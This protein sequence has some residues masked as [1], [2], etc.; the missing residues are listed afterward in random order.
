MDNVVPLAIRSLGTATEEPPA[1]RWL[2]SRSPTELRDLQLAD[3][4]LLPIIR[5]L[6]EGVEPPQGQLFVR[7]AA[8][9]HL[10]RCC[11]QL[12]LCQ[13]VLYY[14]W[15]LSDRVHIKLVAPLGLRDEILYLAH[16][17]RS[18]SHQGQDRTLSRVRASFFW[19]SL[20]LDVALYIRT[21]AAC[22]KNKKPKDKARA[23][24]TSFHAGVP[25]ERVHLDILGPLV[26][27][28]AGNRYVLMMVDQFTKWVECIPLP[29]QTAERL[30]EAALH[31]FFCR[32]GLPLQIHTD[33][34]RN[35]TGHV[36]SDL[37]A[38]LQVAK[39]RTTP[40]HPNANGQVERYN[41]TL[42]QAIRCLLPERQSSWD[43][44]LL[45][46]GMAL[47]AG[48]NRT[49]GFSPNLMM[50][51]REVLSPLELATG[52]GAEN[53][54]EQEPAQ[55]VRELLQR[56]KSVHDEARRHV[57]LVQRAQKRMYDLHL[58]ERSYEKGDLVYQR[59]EAGQVGQSKKLQPIFIGPVLVTQVLS[60]V[61]YRVENRK[62][63]YVLRH[64]RLI[65]CKDRVIPLWVRRKRHDL[66]GGDTTLDEDDEERRQIFFRSGGDNR[67]P[68]PGKKLMLD[69][70][71][72]QEDL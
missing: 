10:W 54:H 37:C 46:V 44:H 68:S 2:P 25:M 27:S 17:V 69:P 49:T 5:W 16:D 24:E 72:R 1:E 67:T 42:L 57:G 38:R 22:S 11:S 71:I 29:D 23:G 6:E 63:S 65:P 55:Y 19:P 47:R 34:G 9:K 41:R 64:D 30:A 15:E 58:H 12:S 51:G 60:P 8:T 35:F 56:M 40:Y 33:Q 4:D 7:S 36:F 26:Q 3:S 43:A 20:S 18:A 14:R 45:L 61:L 66:L 53:L 59:N 21:C 39:T 31:N 32:L 48:V 13:G 52:V 50:L 62:R 70:Q 28:D